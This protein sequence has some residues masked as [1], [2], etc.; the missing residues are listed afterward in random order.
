[1]RLSDSMAD[2][3]VCVCIG[4]G[5]LRL[6]SGLGDMRACVAF[7]SSV[8]MAGFEWMPHRERRMCVG[9]RM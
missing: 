9:V 8:S 7:Y 5:S 1:M 2:L 6:G 3:C 4:R